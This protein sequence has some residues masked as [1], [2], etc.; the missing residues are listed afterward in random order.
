MIE[1]PFSPG[2]LESLLSQDVL[3]Y[4]PSKA[5]HCASQLGAYLSEITAKR[6]ITTVSFDVFD[7][8]LLRGLKSEMR[9]YYELSERF[10]NVLRSSF[11]FD[12]DAKEIFA[13][14]L[15]AFRVGYRTV[16]A[17]CGVREG[18]YSSILPLMLKILNIDSAKIEAIAATLTGI[19]VAYEIENLVVN[20]ILARMFSEGAFD[21]YD[22]MFISDMYLP[23]EIITRLVMNYY[24][25]LT[26]AT[27]FSSAEVGLTKSSGLLYDFVLQTLN[28]QRH[29]I[30]HLGDNIKSDVQMAKARGLSALHM[31]VPED[32]QKL[33]RKEQQRFEKWL[34]ENNF[35]LGLFW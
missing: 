29:E 13:A 28:K 24:P 12:L 20:P 21:E 18:N 11:G 10:E 5:A 32:K 19:E 6:G 16:A 8:L 17:N 26:L 31:P 22:V 34:L 9:R 2:K 14:R 23:L 27:S 35:D 15:T 3:I 33:R 7:T 30:C 4:E 25:K 1:S